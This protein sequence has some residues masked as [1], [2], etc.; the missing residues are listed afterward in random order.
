MDLLEVVVLKVRG[1]RRLTKVVLFYSGF[2]MWA[3]VGVSQQKKLG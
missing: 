3:W 2:L 1:G